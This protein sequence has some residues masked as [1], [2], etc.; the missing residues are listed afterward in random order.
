MTGVQTCALPILEMDANMRQNIL[1]KMGLKQAVSPEGLPMPT[2]EGGKT[3]FPAQDMEAAATALINKYKPE[4]PSMRVNVPE[5][6]R[7]L[8]NFVQNQLKQRQRMEGQMLTDLVDETLTKQLGDMGKEFDPEITAALRDSVMTLVKGEKPKTGRRTPGIAELAPKPDAQGNISIPAIIPGRRL[9]INPAQLR[10]DAARVAEANTP[11]D[12]NLPEALDYLTAAQRFRNDSLSS[13]NAAMMKGRTRQTDAQR[14]LDTG[15]SVFT[16]VERLVLGHAPRLKGEYEAMK[17]MLDD[18]KQV[19]SNTLPLLMT[20]GKRG[21][22]E[23]YLPNE[24]LLRN[25]FKNA[26]SLRQVANILGPD[27]QSA[28]LLMKGTV[29]WLRGKGVVNN[30]GIVDP[31]DR[32]STRLNSSHIPLSRMPSSA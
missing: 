3:L 13:Y 20:Q 26:D 14:I 31:K 11:I 25:A 32:K 7:L 22:M 30:D 9:V 17:V 12:L 18:Y 15:D 6:I 16:D 5:P 27:E 8:D 24:D 4:R 10:Q 2:R 1:R 21:G 23:Y 19:Y 29:D 28:N